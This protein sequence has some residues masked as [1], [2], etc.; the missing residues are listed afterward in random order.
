MS[1]VHHVAVTSQTIALLR[2][3]LAAYEAEHPGVITRHAVGY[4]GKNYLIETSAPSSQC[5]MTRQRDRAAHAWFPQGPAAPRRL[6][7]SGALVG[8]VQQTSERSLR[9]RCG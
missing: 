8:G 1:F 6:I 4:L 2:R 7:G 3:F 5:E 9:R